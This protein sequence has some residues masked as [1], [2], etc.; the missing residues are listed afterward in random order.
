V[1]TVRVK[2]ADKTITVQV[3]NPVGKSTESYLS[4]LDRTIQW[5]RSFQDPFEAY[6]DRMK[7]ISREPLDA[8]KSGLGIARITYEGRA[9]LDFYLEEDNTL[10]VS[11]VSNIDL[12]ERRWR[13]E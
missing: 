5:V 12:P 8:S 6:V 4:E 1:V 13:N 10:S 9:A 11:A 3:S 7:A 2:I